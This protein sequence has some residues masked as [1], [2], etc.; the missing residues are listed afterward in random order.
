[1]ARDLQ[2]L[3]DAPFRARP[4]N[5]GSPAHSRLLLRTGERRV[6]EALDALR[7]DSPPAQM[8]TV[9]GRVRVYFRT[10]HQ[11]YL[12]G[13]S[14]AGYG[15]RAD[16]L[17]ATS[18][19]E[20]QSLN[21]TIDSAGRTYA[22]RAKRTQDDVLAGSATAIALLFSAFAFL[23]RRSAI[24]H[25]ET[26]RL[27]EENWCLLD[28]SRA[29]ARADALTGLPNR[30]ALVADLTAAV[31][32][33]ADRR[34]LLIVFDLD[35]FKQYN[36]A[37]GHPAGDLLL[38]RLGRRLEAA[39]APLQGTAYRMGGDEFCVLAP[40][41]ESELVVWASFNALSERGE[42][43]E[44]GASY[45]MAEIP[46]EASSVALALHLA[47]VRMYDDKATG[48]PSADR[49]STDVLMALISE[50]GPDLR[51]HVERVAALTELTARRMG[52]SDDATRRAALAAKLHDV[53]KA[54][55]PDTIVTKAGSLDPAEWEFIHRHTVIGEHI[56]AAAPA[57]AQV[58]EVVRSSHERF[59]G[60][61]YPDGLEGEAIPI[62]ARI[63]TVCDAYDTMTN[64]SVYQRRLVRSD[65]IA[66][67]RRHAGTQFDPHVV[68]AFCALPADQLAPSERRAA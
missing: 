46:A 48:R 58:A 25:A 23:L 47:D 20:L 56:I 55:I 14:P 7:D 66:E 65:A 42:G 21:A 12:A 17:S 60:T 19:G 61:G 62:G 4:R 36:D 44:V 22:G 31:A 34:A 13:I 37:F 16:R 32:W 51:E 52:L 24:A 39:V 11:I 9:P 8:R 59:D 3:Q 26:R 68:D 1:M 10:L 49:Q 18:G 54:A 41:E 53:G 15:A 43:F 2:A 50:R 45:G 64:E 67:L 63:I 28:T 33:E 6:L 30:R 35:G 57:L 38:R 29:E 40:A 5:G 27:A